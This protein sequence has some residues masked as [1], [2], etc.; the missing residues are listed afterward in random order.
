MIYLLK[1]AQDPSAT[2]SSC[3]HAKIGELLPHCAWIWCSN[4]LKTVHPD[5][6]HT[7]HCKQRGVNSMTRATSGP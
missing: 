7:C 3:F 6:W 2:S 1:A 4:Y 5:G